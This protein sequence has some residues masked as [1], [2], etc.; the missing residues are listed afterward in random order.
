M[1][2]ANI[3]FPDEFVFKFLC[4]G[5]VIENKAITYLIVYYKY[6]MFYLLHPSLTNLVA[7]TYCI[8]C[9]ICSKSL[10]QLSSDMKEYEPIKFS[11]KIQ[12]D[13]LMNRNRIIK[14]LEEIQ[15]IFS[16][17]S[18]VICI[19]NFM[20]CFSNLGELIFYSP[21]RITLILIEA[22]FMSTSTLVTLL[23]IFY[24][25]GQVP[26]ELNKF[27]RINRKQCQK[28]AFLG[29]IEEN[30]T[31]DRMLFQEETFVLSGC[32]MIYFTRSGILTVLGTLLTYGLLVV[33]VDLKKE[34]K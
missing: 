1:V 26:L 28:R 6:S 14:V 2:F 24:S 30:A 23:S 25:A 32:E 7:L 5:I 33:S 20:S 27:S 13:F 18:F 15:E 12:T 3:E 19:A 31:L 34:N 29:E 8:S 21:K 11:T 10:Q 4:Y 16:K 17:A 22:I 9:Q